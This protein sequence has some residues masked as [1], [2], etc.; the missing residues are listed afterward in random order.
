MSWI[1]TARALN[2]L[3]YI[4]IASIRKKTVLENQR[5]CVKMMGLNWSWQGLV[6]VLAIFII[7]CITMI[8]L[9]VQSFNLLTKVA[10]I[11][12]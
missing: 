4:L 10:K 9:T 5:D 2:G 1:V 3:F 11:T 12:D 8:T 7:D 6:S